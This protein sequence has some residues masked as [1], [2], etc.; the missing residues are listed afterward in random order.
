M[1]GNYDLV[2]FVCLCGEIVDE[3]DI[4]LFMF[5]YE[6]VEK[7]GSV[8]IVGEISGYLYLVVC[9][10]C[11]GRFICCV[12]FVIDGMCLILFVFG[13][14]IGGLNVIYDVFG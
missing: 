7:I 4:G 2:V 13:V 1:I 5:C 14:L 9:V 6:L 12:C 3:I 11:F 10:C 8:D